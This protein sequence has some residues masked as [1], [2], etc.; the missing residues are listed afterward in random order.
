MAQPSR[1]ST[2]P[3]APEPFQRAMVVGQIYAE[4]LYGLAEQADRV[5]ETQAELEQVAAL[6]R[7]EPDFREFFAS[8][9]VPLDR[10][11]IAVERAFRGHV[12]DL[13]C[14]ALGVIARHGRMGALGSIA[15]CFRTRTW[16]ARRQVAVEVTSAA[17][18]DE[19][20]RQAIMK[21]LT[22]HLS[23][24]PILT[25]HVDPEILGGLVVRV[26]DEVVD[27]SVRS[28]LR[29]IRKSFSRRLSALTGGPGPMPGLR[30][31][32]P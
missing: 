17:P 9:L 1:K 30:A 12:S 4:A 6:L 10:K 23:A 2:L 13:T 7:A 29:Q 20:S 26:G 22:D 14:D 24:T 16:H 32:A 8:P 27:L 18:L 11:L 25:E 3:P 28:E 15:W 5:D 31:D 21:G 19:E